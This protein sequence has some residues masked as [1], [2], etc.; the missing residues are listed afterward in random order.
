MGISFGDKPEELSLEANKS[1]ERQLQDA[2]SVTWG[3]A[4]SLARK[5]NI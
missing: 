1:V 2:E 3:L 5:G 4:A